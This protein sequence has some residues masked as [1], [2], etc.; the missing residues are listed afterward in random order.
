MTVEREYFER[1]VKFLGGL[2]VGDL[3]SGKNFYEHV[4]CARVWGLR[5]LRL[6]EILGYLHR[7]QG[8]PIIY[9][10]AKKVDLEDFDAVFRMWLRFVRY[11][12][13]KNTERVLKWLEK[14]PKGFTF[15][16][17]TLMRK[18]GGKQGRYSRMIKALVDRGIVE[19]TKRRRRGYK[20]Y[21]KI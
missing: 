4:G 7:V 21:R 10:V 17:K 20:V 3:V 8:R 19:E 9:R 5:F 18:F 15:T 2:N 14:K 12:T 16:L 6:F 11:A 1:G 13:S